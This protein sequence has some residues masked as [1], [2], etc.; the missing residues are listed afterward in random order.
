[1]R[2]RIVRSLLCRLGALASVG[3]PDLAGARP[4]RRIAMV[5]SGRCAR[6]RRAA[7]REPAATR[8][9]HRYRTRGACA[10]SR[11]PSTR[12]APVCGRARFLATISIAC[13]SSM[14]EALLDHE[15]GRQGRARQRRGASSSSARTEPA[16]IGKL[17]D[18][19]IL[20][21]DRRR[22][23]GAASRPREGTVLRPDGT[24]VSV[25]YTVGNVLHDARRD[26]E[27]GVRGAQHR[28][29]QTRRAA[30]PLSRPYRLADEDR[31]PHAVPASAAAG[32]RARASH[33]AVRRDPVS[34]HRPVQRHQRHVRPRGR[35]HEPRDLRAPRARRA[36]E[37]SHAGR[38]GRRRV[39]GADHGLR[40][41][42]DHNEDLDE[43]APQLLQPPASRSKCT[44]KRSSSRPAWVSPCIRAMATT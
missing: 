26:R 16:L 7:E 2:R 31:E 39:R 17:A 24:T 44:A 14:G 3:S 12:C 29:A 20:S 21:S 9:G 11:T 18:E 27:Q 33:A 30:D 8:H 42:R 13:S 41:P 28:R 15:Y 19:L 25:S 34:R 22:A 38:L 1:M 10:S 23:E 4:H 37:N 36:R 32:H 43:I 6:G 35:R 5:S 40:A